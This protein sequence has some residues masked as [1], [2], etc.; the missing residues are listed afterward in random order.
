MK[1][2][3]RFLAVLLT[4]FMLIGIMASGAF[5]AVAADKT[6]VSVKV[7]GTAKVTITNDT[8]SAATIKATISDAEVFETDCPTAGLSVAKTNGSGVVTVTGLAVGEATLTLK[9][10]STTVATITV[11]VTAASASGEKN[12]PKFTDDTLADGSDL[13]AIFDPTNKAFYAGEIPTDDSFKFAAEST[14]GTQSKLKLTATYASKQKNA[15]T[16]KFFT[17]A[18]DNSASATFAGSETNKVPTVTEDTTYT[19]TVTAKDDHG[20]ESRSY[21]FTILANPSIT[22]D[23]KKEPKNPIIWGSTKAWSFQVKGTNVKDNGWRIDNGDA[24]LVTEKFTVAGNKSPSGLKF[25]ESNGT[26]E[27]VGDAW[28][29]GTDENEIFPQDWNGGDVKK[30]VDVFAVRGAKVENK[31]PIA[32]QDYAAIASQTFTLTFQGSEP[33]FIQSAKDYTFAYDTEITA[34]KDNV[35]VVEG[36]GVIT[37]KATDLPDGMKFEKVNEEEIE[38]LSA[39][40]GGNAKTR[41]VYAFTG[42]PTVSTKGTTVTITAENPYSK[43]NKKTVSIKP[44]VIVTASAVTIT[45]ADTVVDSL[46]GNLAV[47]ASFKINLEAKPAPIKWSAKNLPAG[48]KLNPNKTDSTKATIEG[49]LT[50]ATKNLDDEKNTFEIT[51]ANADFKDATVATL[52][53]EVIVWA[54]PEFSTKSDKPINVKTGEGGIKFSIATKNPVETWT[55]KIGETDVITDGYAIQDSAGETKMVVD[56]ENNKKPDTSL[57]FGGAFD[58]VPASDIPM[59]VTVKTGDNQTASATFNIHVTGVAPKFDKGDFTLV[60]G[61]DKA[62]AAYNLKDGTPLVIWKAYID[63]KTIDK[64]KGTKGSANVDLETEPNALTGL[65]FTVDEN[66]TTKTTFTYTVPDTGDVALKKLPVTVEAYNP[67]I[68][69]KKPS[70]GKVTITVEGD[71]PS[72]TLTALPDT[73]SAAN[74]ETTYETDKALSEYDNKLDLNVIAGTALGDLVLTAGGGKPLAYSVKPDKKNGITASDTD[75]TITFSGTPESV[76]KDTAVKFTIE[77]KNASTGKSSKVAVTINILPKPTADSYAITPKAVTWGKNVKAAPKLTATNKNVTWYV[78]GLKVGTAEEQPFE[79]TEDGAKDASTAL[80]ALGL[81]FDSKKGAISGKVNYATGTADEDAI[82]ITTVAAGAMEVSDPFTTTIKVVGEKVKLTTKTVPLTADITAQSDVETEDART[83]KT[84][85]SGATDKHRAKITWTLGKS[86]PSE[87]SGLTV[88][89]SEADTNKNEGLTALVVPST[90]KVTKKAAI[91]VTFNNYGTESTGKFTVTVDG[92]TPEID[93]SNA[94]V[95][96]LEYGKSKAYT[97]K[98]KDTNVVSEK[99]KWKITSKNLPKGVSAAVKAE[100]KG[101][102]SLS[103]KVGPKVTDSKASVSVTVTDSITKKTSEAQDFSLTITPYEEPTDSSAEAPLVADKPE[104]VTDTKEDVTSDKELGEGTVKLGS[105]RTAEGLT[106]AQRAAIEDKGYVIAAVLPEVE[107]EDASGAYVLEVGEL[108][109]A[110]ATGAELVYFAFASKPTTD[111][112]YAIFA[113]AE[114]GAETTVIPENRKVTVEAWLNVGTKY[115]PVIAVKANAAAAEAKTEEDVKAK[116]E[117]KAE[118]AKEESKEDS[119]K[120]E[121]KEVKE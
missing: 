24:D 97:I 93:D 54:K 88:T 28:K 71:D 94:A 29:P 21:T 16:I 78:T 25:D 95:G 74:E 22:T 41:V 33:K 39:A 46:N 82:V 106:S 117:E 62:S 68:N 26:F 103:F 34:N 61:G 5:A 45:N 81:A 37:L 105:A 15:P 20:E 107:V 43:K 110:A 67:N 18:S 2:H 14:T 57:L 52:K 19:M 36:P 6:S 79:Q 115:A 104:A 70:T 113:N 91:P 87:V 27:I 109:E 118:E 72:W 50:T 96:T 100:S 11:K 42:T 76:K 108:D 49:K 102:A 8:S 13:G 55:A 17:V 111:D 1:K 116:A 9:N 32:D 60:A 112:E 64:L 58:R 53:N 73:Y 101:T 10:G 98:V 121:T 38:D 89:K 80:E 92:A 59:V 51:A 77:A 99:L 83:L 119:A 86:I 30:T 7:G 40:L 47:G 23:P 31:T 66:D 35:I 85:L 84:N 63:G 65:S 12:P 69:P 114:D 90:R 120:T 3:S 4:A 56:E 48:L 75:G 44:K